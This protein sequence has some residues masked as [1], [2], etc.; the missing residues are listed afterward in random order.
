MGSVLKDLI[1]ASG[2]FG[3]IILLDIMVTGTGE[4]NP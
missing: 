1:I 4:E 2:A 3:L